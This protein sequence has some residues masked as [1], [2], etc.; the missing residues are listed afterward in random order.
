[1]ITAHLF[2]QRS[3]IDTYREMIGLLGTED[4]PTRYLLERILVRKESHA[5][6]LAALVSDLA[7]HPKG[8]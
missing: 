6:K 3:A 8:R 4:P 7:S 1:M 2:A 5:K